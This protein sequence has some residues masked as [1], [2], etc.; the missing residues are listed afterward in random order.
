MQELFPDSKTRLRHI[1]EKQVYGL[2]PTEIIYGIAVSYVL[3]FD[4]TRDIKKHNFKNWML[5]P[6]HGME[7]F[8][9]S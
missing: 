4:E 9:R 7:H 5:R 6:M 1:F 2:A 8:R 3:G